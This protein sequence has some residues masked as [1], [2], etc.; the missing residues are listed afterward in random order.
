[1]FEHA[2]P[3][4]LRECELEARTNRVYSK[5]LPNGMPDSLLTEFARRWRESL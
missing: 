5:S 1:V 4:L 3:Y 2:W